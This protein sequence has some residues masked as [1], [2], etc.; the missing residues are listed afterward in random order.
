MYVVAF[1]ETETMGNF[2]LINLVILFN[3]FFPN[4]D[5]NRHYMCNTVSLLSNKIHL[6]YAIVK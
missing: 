4:I 3:S 2:T 1:E 6:F 5:F